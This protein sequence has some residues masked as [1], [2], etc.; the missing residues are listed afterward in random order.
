MTG[1]NR[2]GRLNSP[3][4]AAACGSQILA[5]LR[6][7]ALRSQRRSA[8]NPYPSSNLC[9]GWVSETTPRDLPAFLRSHQF[10]V[11]NVRP[12]KQR[13]DFG[14]KDYRPDTFFRDQVL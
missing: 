2:K 7:S 9:P 10:K 8:V 11:D 1:P 6:A 12:I 14:W 5:D 4:I 13:C 3:L